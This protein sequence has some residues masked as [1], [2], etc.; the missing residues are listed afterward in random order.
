MTVSLA[1]EYIPRRMG[2]LGYE[3]YTIRFRHFCLQPLEV[4]KI[5]AYNNIF[6][7]T[8]PPLFIRVESNFAF[9]ELNR[10]LINELQYEHTGDLT[11]SNLSETAATDV[12]FIQVIPK[13]CLP[14]G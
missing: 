2:E 3:Q 5:F 11:I 9:Y 1:L 14:C 6:L 7:L 13:K 10:N 8:D 12:K 4:R